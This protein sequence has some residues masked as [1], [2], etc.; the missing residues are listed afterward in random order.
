MRIVSWLLGL[1]I[2]TVVAAYF[3]VFSPFGNAMIK[4]IVEGKINKA[5]NLKSSFTTFS[6]TSNQFEILL[7]LDGDNTIYAKGAYSLSEKSLDIIYDVKLN[8][9]ENLNNLTK[10]ALKGTLN[11]EGTLKGDQEFMKIDGVSDL[12]S[13]DTSYHLELT[14]LKPTSIISTIKNADLTSLLE[15]MGKKPYADGKLDVDVD[16]K[17]ITPH[18]LDGDVVLSTRNGNLNT[19]FLNKDLDLELPPTSF[20]MKLDATLKGD[21]VE[22]TYALES[23]LAKVNS[24]GN[25]IPKPLKVD[26]RYTIDVKEL[27]LL[28]EITNADIRGPLKLNGTIQGTRKKMLVNGI[29]DIAS[30]DTVLSLTL[31]DLKA[32]S[33]K[34]KMK[35]LQLSQVLYL[36]KQPHYADGILDLDVDISS[37]E[38][39]NLQGT[40]IS[41]VSKGLLDSRYITKTSKFKTKMPKTRF[42][43]NGNTNLQGKTANTQ[44]DLKSTLANLEV[45]KM[46]Y[47]LE[48]KSVTSDYE[49]Y[50]PK[51]SSLYFI[52]E[53]HLEGAIKLDGTIKKSKEMIDITM[54]SKIAGGVLEA[55]IHNDD[56]HAKIKSIQTLEAMKILKYPAV[57]KASLNGV[58]DYD[59]ALKKGKF[60]GDLVDG[61]FEDNMVFA[62]VKKYAKIDM[63]KENFKG[64]VSANIDNENV[65]ASFDLKS[66]TSSIKTIKTKINSKTQVID[67]KIDII[68]NKHPMSVILTGNKSKPKVV[69]DAKEIIKE[70]FKKEINNKVGVFLQDLF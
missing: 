61:G 4:P 44:L 19:D 63:Y 59:K 68:V 1:F 45:K 11:T 37:L 21:A 62:L 12:A 55:T 47:N 15:L 64:K 26:A 60:T 69:I 53:R 57:F 36:A 41:H 50:V 20:D 32:S 40:V 8:K 7:A 30:S 17:N 10:Q 48:D 38:K 56:V 27:A 70:Q 34:A 24:N 14:K 3:I 5:T 29:S 58:L 18:F 28:K 2:F 39:G 65:L 33:L 51:L 9:L 43:L 66:N 52:I 49:I 46:T 23:N 13:S 35:N 16:F 42:T 67:S 25:I 54:N 31:K 6:F 22:Y